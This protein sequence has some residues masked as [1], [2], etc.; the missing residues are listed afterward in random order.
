MI[1]LKN[2]YKTTTVKDLLKQK[3]LSARAITK[4][5]QELG[6]M[7]VDGRNVIMTDIIE[8]NKTLCLN[9]KDKAP[10]STIPLSNKPID[11]VFEDEHI[12]IVD[13]PNNLPTI[14]SYNFEDSLAG[15]VLNHYN[16]EFVFRALNRLDAHT[17][18][19][20]I[21][22]KDVVTENLLDAAGNIRKWYI[23]KV[24]GKTKRKG[25]VNAPIMDDE[26]LKK[27]IVHDDGLP[28]ITYYK[29][30][31]YKNNI[32][33]IKCNLVYGRTNQIRCHLAHIGH[34]L[35]NDNKYNSTANT[36][37][38]GVYYLR[39][40]MAKFKHPY[41]EKTITIKLKY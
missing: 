25:C 1:Y 6:L 5:R 32:S 16:G 34:P 15:R 39:C 40:F 20:V 24:E 19:L 26:K 9:P 21:I 29:R 28:A 36:N 30:L 38:N 27:R 14:P 3:G 35:V 2:K 41:T 11:V 37:S 31:K 22:A 23:A 13:K 10:S 18:G 4:L 7:K 12:L 17:T 8:R 33:T